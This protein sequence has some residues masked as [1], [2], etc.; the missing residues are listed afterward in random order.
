MENNCLILVKKS[1]GKKKKGGPNIF[2]QQ[3]WGPNIHPRLSLRVFCQAMSPSTGQS[4]YPLQA[5][6]FVGLLK[7]EYMHIH[8]CL[9]GTGLFYAAKSVSLSQL[10]LL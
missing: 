8:F 9:T 6:V 2:K 1:L 3:V 4:E 10:K 5:V 7:I